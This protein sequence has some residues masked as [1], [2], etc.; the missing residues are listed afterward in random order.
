T[1]KARCGPATARRSRPRGPAAARSLEPLYSSGC[2]FAL[3]DGLLALLDGGGR[4][5]DGYEL[6]FG[7]L[8]DVQRNVGVALVA[9][10][11]SPGVLDDEVV[12]EVADDQ[13]G[14]A[15]VVSARLFRRVENA[16]A[17]DL[18]EFLA[19]VHA[20][21]N[22]VARGEHLP[23]VVEFDRL[24]LRRQLVLLGVRGQLFVGAL[25]GLGIVRPQLG[26]NGAHLDEVRSRL[27]AADGAVAAGVRVL[28]ALRVAL[29]LL[30]LV[31]RVA[32]RQGRGLDAQHVVQEFVGVRPGEGGAAHGLALVAD[33]GG[34]LAQVDAVGRIDVG[35]RGR[36]GLRG[37]VLALGVVLRV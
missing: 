22:R 6:R 8:E 4:G 1:P 18:L 16:A 23:E 17:V 26:R 10:A 34:V 7:L 37:L 15:P 27:G 36:Q 32:A 9:P 30:E 5:N 24:N 25:R 21:V 35:D 13:H 28:V 20:D 11:R 19:G 14:V 33:G 31:H 12:A 3:L 2:R 29:Q